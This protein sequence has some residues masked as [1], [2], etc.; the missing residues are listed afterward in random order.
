[1]NNLFGITGIKVEFCAITY[2]DT[3]YLNDFLNRH[4]GDII[5]IQFQQ[6]EFSAQQVMVVYKDTTKNN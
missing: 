6:N 1:M 5:D 2:G 3:S 4:D